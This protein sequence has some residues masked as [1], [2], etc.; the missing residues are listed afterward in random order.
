MKKNAYTGRD[1]VSGPVKCSGVNLNLVCFDCFFV[2]LGG[3]NFH[4]LGTS[5]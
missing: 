2:F 3:I 5:E 1:G 4:P